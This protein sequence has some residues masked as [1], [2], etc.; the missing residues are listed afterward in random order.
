MSKLNKKQKFVKPYVIFLTSLILLMVG[1]NLLNDVAVVKAADSNPTKA[2]FSVQ[3][4]FDNGASAGADEKKHSGNLWY[5][6]VKPGSTVKV[7]VLITN[8]SKE[9]RSF[10]V[11]AYTA[12]TNESGTVEYSSPK[13]KMDSSLKVDFRSLFKNNDVKVD[14]P[15]TNSTSNGQV[16]VSLTAEIPNNAFKG[17]IMGG[18]NVYAYD[19]TEKLDK[20]STSLVNKFAFVIP[21]IFNVDY[22][23]PTGGIDSKSA[24]SLGEVYP[25]VNII[26]RESEAKIVEKIRNSKSGILPTFNTYTVVTMKGNSKLKAVSETQVNQMAPNSVWEN[27]IK[28][29]NQPL[30]AG[31]YH[32]VTKVRVVGE[33]SPIQDK[34]SVNKKYDFKMEKDFTVTGAQASQ[35]NRQMGIKPNYLWLWITLGVLAVILLV[36]A[37]WYFARRT[38]KNNSV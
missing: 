21:V 15:G 25:Q 11:S 2:D 14:V 37:V 36:L 6:N 18:L 29:G 30:K 17:T 28:L 13:P 9:K 5:D 34:T 38:K 1:V 31:N 3:P 32:I 7:T 16:A 33:N 8:K 19:P 20:K 4:F 35:L 27:P 12:S 23:Y 24:M 22:S 26:G 10:K